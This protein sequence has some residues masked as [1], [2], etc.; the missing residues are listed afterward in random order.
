[1][2]VLRDSQKPTDLEIKAT[3]TSE[4]PSTGSAILTVSKGYRWGSFK[5]NVDIDVEVDVGVGA[6]L[7]PSCSYLGRTQG[8][9]Q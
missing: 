8:H 9:V 6:D 3:Q 7:K 4:R 2:E 1:M 5:A